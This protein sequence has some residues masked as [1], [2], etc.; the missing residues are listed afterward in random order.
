MK[1]LFSILA[2]LCL[3]FNLSGCGASQPELTPTGISSSCDL[4]RNI[5]VLS[6]VK[7]TMSADDGTLLFYCSFQQVQMN[8]YNH[9][10]SEKISQ[11]LHSRT[12]SFL[13]NRSV[14]EAQAKQDY[15]NVE[16]WSEYFIDITYTPMLLDQN[17]LSLSGNITS[18]AGG[19]HP[20]TANHSVTYDLETGNT[21]S[22]DDI[23][24]AEC[25]TDTLYQLTLSALEEQSEELYDDYADALGEHF[26]DNLHSIQNWYLSNSGL[27]FYFSP[28]D[29][30]PY[31]SGTIVAELPY[32]LLTGNLKECYFPKE[33]ELADGSICASNS[34]DD[35][36]RFSCVTD[37]PLH[38]NGTTFYLYPDS[39]VTD[40][41]IEIGMLYPDQNRFISQ[42]TI[43][44]ASALGIE[45]AIRITANFSE[46]DMILQLKYRSSQQEHTAVI[47]FEENSNTIML[48]Y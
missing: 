16:F 15:S 2:G 14:I 42:S 6:P 36:D 41:R 43:F 44:A 17:I 29:I 20:S 47:T 37:V 25:T 9:V 1:R 40:L 46:A 12:V 10:V 11:D 7:E 38:E 39:T 26:S 3:I 31:A 13:S 27:C 34:E 35:L 5:L 28:Y 19:P 22:L 18:Y 45:D 48:N 8:L 33:P 32:H 21:I 30:A 4:P 23:L 24:T